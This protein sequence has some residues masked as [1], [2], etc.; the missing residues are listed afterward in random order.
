MISKRLVPLSPYKTETTPSRI[1]LSSNELAID[2]PE[3]VRR[4]I[5]EEVSKIPFNRYPD[6][7]ARALK[8][9]I[10]QR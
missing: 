3:E 5:A 4:R 8:E 1:K 7:E 10:A 2:F 6:P 9:A